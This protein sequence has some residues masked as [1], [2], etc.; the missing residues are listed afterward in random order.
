MP[1]TPPADS[2]QLPPLRLAAGHGPS[3]A[4][5]IEHAAP[6]GLAR[7]LNCRTC[8]GGCPF[9]PAMDYGPHGI[10]RLIQFGQRDE[11]L[12]SNTIWLCVACHT[13]T[14]ACPMSIDVAAVMDT[15]RHLALAEGVAVAEPGILDFH[16]EVLRSIEHHGRTHKLEIMLRYKVR[17]G[18]WL[19]DMDKGLAML[20]RRKL[21]LIPNEIRRPAEL[22]PLFQKTWR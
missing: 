8:S 16:R 22:A 4:V 1:P 21:N 15:L 5:E 14:S 6:A 9:Y 18:G 13:C 19:A 11:V 2:P 17:Q 20:T 10:M 12:A 7:C 3:L